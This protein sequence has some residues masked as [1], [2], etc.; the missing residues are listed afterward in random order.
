M[1]GLAVMLSISRLITSK[2]IDEIDL[3]ISSWQEF[4]WKQG[5][6]TEGKTA[7]IEVLPGFGKIEGG[8]GC[9]CCDLAWQKYAVAV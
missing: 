1:Y 5:H 4:I 8:G 3:N 9:H 7:K 2:N 6:H